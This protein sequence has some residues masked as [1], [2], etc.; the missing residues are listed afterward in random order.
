[1]ERRQRFL[2]GFVTA[3]LTFGSLMAFVGQN[4]LHTFK[5]QYRHYG[6]E[7]AEHCRNMPNNTIPNAPMPNND[8][9]NH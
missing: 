7:H 9:L 8:G 3:A 2:V 5:E 4:R 1:M 6:F